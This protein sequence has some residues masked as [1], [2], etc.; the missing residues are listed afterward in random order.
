MPEIPAKPSSPSKATQ[1]KSTSKKF[2]DNYTL[3]KK[4]GSGAFSI[5]RE[6][7]HKDS[8]KKFAVK[9]IKKDGM[10]DDDKAGL[11]LEIKILKEV[12]CFI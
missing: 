12:P 1:A 3:E 11:V 6:A 10:S 9:C 7:T 8:G 4:L 5:V 2:E